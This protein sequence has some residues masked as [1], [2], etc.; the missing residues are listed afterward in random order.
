MEKRKSVVK[1]I[2]VILLLIVLV[3]V[4]S[5]GGWLAV[6]AHRVNELLV[7][8]TASYDAMKES[9][10]AED[11]SKAVTYAREV[12]ASSN[13]MQEELHGT[14][15]DIAV[16]MPVAGTDVHV[17][18]TSAK[19]SSHLANDAVLPV[20]DAWDDLRAE[21]PEGEE[22]DLSKLGEKISQLTALVYTLED[23]SA[24]VDECAEQMK[25]LPAAH[26]EELN[27]Y[28]DDLNSAIANAQESMDKMEEALNFYTS[29]ESVVNGIMSNVDIEVETPAAA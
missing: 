22:L 11:Y 9:I 14:Q 8:S 24:V 7:Q 6:S 3:A 15:W 13:A 5:F 12:A 19:V 27:K 1:T 17:A 25:G 26:S 10:A 4:L 21:L 2:F 29:L 18:R 20:L 23:A 28:V 16:K